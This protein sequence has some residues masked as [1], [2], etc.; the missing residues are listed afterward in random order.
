[1]ENVS[2]LVLFKNYLLAGANGGKSGPPVSIKADDLDK[3]FRRL[4]PVLDSKAPLFTF[5]E[6]GLI[7]STFDVDICVNGSP[8]KYRIIAA[9]IT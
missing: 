4:T 6:Q 2:G 5:T 3:N 8:K 9:Q 1:M 7:P